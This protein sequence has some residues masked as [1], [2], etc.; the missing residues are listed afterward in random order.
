MGRGESRVG[1]ELNEVERFGFEDV[2]ISRDHLAGPDSPSEIWD[3][4]WN[5]DLVEE[6]VA[7][8]VGKKNNNLGSKSDYQDAHPNHLVVFNAAVF[9]GKWCSWIGDLDV[10]LAQSKLATLARK[11]SSPV[12]ILSE[13]DWTASRQYKDFHPSQ[14]S[15]ATFWPDGSIEFDSDFASRTSDGKL[16]R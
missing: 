3:E 7:G 14:L 10:T 6:S 2:L 12:A 8:I 1:V 4:V 5:H 13:Q 9:I 11:F 15:K 16:N